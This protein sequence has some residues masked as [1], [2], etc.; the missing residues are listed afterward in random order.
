MKWIS[1]EDKEPPE[2]ELILLNTDNGITVGSFEKNYKGYDSYR[3]GNDCI[4][5]DY[6]FNLGDISVHHWM[7]LPE[8]PKD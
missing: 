6:D 1:V 2:G 8:P 5:W 4:A 7:P 3:L